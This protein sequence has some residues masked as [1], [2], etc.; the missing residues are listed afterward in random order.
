MPRPDDEKA[1]ALARQ[2]R[3]VALVIAGSGL[4][5]LFAPALRAQFGLSF[6]VEGLL[7]LAAMGGFLWALIVTFRIWSA[8][9]DD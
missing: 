9:R 2:G 6:R 8:S 1:R 7:Y 3:T 4:L 5:A